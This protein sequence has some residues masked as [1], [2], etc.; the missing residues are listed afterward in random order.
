MSSNCPRQ[1]SSRNIWTGPW[2][3]FKVRPDATRVSLLRLL[4]SRRC[5]PPDDLDFRLIPLS[6]T[7]TWCDSA[8]L[9]SSCIIL[10]QSWH[11][12]SR[13]TMRCCEMLWDA[14]L[15]GGLVHR[16]PSETIPTWN[17]DPF[18]VWRL[19]PFVAVT[20]RQ[21][22]SEEFKTFPKLKHI[23]VNHTVE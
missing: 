1:W 8:I 13:D 14:E 23:F 20:M 2:T 7:A 6:S 15:V 18:Q 11:E 21:L 10:Y 3:R 16:S 17:S 19:S 4:T 9:V 22:L 12:Y 5:G